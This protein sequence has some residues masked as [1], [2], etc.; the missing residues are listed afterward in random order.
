MKKLL[1][2]V[3]SILALVSLV[4]TLDELNAYFMHNIQESLKI[5]LFCFFCF[6][7]YLSLAVVV[8]SKYIKLLTI[9][10][11]S[12]ILSSCNSSEV[13]TTAK[14]LETSQKIKVRVDKDLYKKGDTI[15]VTCR[16][17]EWFLK[18]EFYNF[19]DLSETHKG[20]YGDSSL[21]F[22]TNYKAVIL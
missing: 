11:I 7:A 16:R 20:Y 1:L 4:L 10:A 3:L 17:A 22:W 13:I 21:V 5:A 9:V 12:F 8:Y 6:V 15:I 18:N 14:V 2:I 19:K